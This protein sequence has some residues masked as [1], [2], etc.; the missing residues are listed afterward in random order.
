MFSVGASP[1]N[2]SS[3]QLYG[4]WASNVKADTTVKQAVTGWEADPTAFVQDTKWASMAERYALD[5]DDRDLA[6][7]IRV[8]SKGFLS[9]KRKLAKD[10][11][12]AALT[13]LAG[14]NGANRLIRSPYKLSS[15]SPEAKQL[16]WSRFQG[17]GWNPKGLAD[18]ER[19][20]LQLANRAPFGSAPALPAGLNVDGLGDFVD[21]GL[22]YYKP[23][24]LSAATRRLLGQA[25]RGTVTPNADVAAQVRAN[26]LAVYNQ[27][28]AN[29]ATLDTAT[30]LAMAAAGP[31]YSQFV[32]GWIQ[33]S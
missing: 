5:P 22:N 12:G 2:S 28:L 18:G 16:V 20:F 33:G 13:W 4:G 11:N 1:F 6:A 17:L 26:T 3:R 29:G 25:R 15:L 19:M 9:G 27:A 7:K 32:Q 31:A 23:G 21:A 8:Y 14:Y 24:K 30:S 10:G